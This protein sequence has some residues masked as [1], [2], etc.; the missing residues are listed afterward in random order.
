MKKSPSKT[1]QM[2]VLPDVPV[3]NGLLKRFFRR[4]FI[5]PLY[6]LVA[7]PYVILLYEIDPQAEGILGFVLHIIA[8]LSLQPTA[9]E[10]N[11][12]DIGMA[13]VTLTILL[14]IAVGIIRRIR[15]FKKAAISVTRGMVIRAAICAAGFFA[16]GLLAAVRGEQVDQVVIPVVIGVCVPILFLFEY[17]L[18]LVFQSGHTQKP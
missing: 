3:V 8:I 17:A 16:N 18:R 6:A 5:L 2:Q 7:I 9:T 12:A 10:F 14:E 13:V 15:P 4:L 1:S 11:A